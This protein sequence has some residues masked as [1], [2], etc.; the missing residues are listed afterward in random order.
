MKIV[1][2]KFVE[3][4]IKAIFVHFFVVPFHFIG[5]QIKIHKTIF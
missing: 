4:E 3:E 2:L 1:F 5:L